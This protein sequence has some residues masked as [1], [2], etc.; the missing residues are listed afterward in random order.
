MEGTKRHCLLGG[1][2]AERWINCPP[3]ARL[4]EDMDD[5]TSEYAIEGTKAHALC[6]YKL[7]RALGNKAEKPDPSEFDRQMDESS[8]GYVSFVLEQAESA[9]EETGDEPVTMVEHEVAYDSWVKGG[10]GTCDALIA[11]SGRL[12]VID[13]KYG[14][15]VKVDATDNSQLKIYALGAIQELDCLYDFD[16]VL[17]TIYQPRIGNVSTWE[18]TKAELLKWAEEVLKPAAE[19][20]DRGEGIYRSGPW[21]RFCK[22]RA[23]CRE[24]S[25]VARD[26]LN[27]EFRNPD[28]LSDTEIEEI[29]MKADEVASYLSDLKDY[30]LA[31]A[32][33]GKKWV[34]FKLV[35]GRSVRKFT[36][37]GK[38]I[39]VL[40]EN[41]VNPFDAKLRSITDIEKE[42]GKARFKALLDGYVAK[43]KGKPTLAPR[44]DRREEIS[45]AKADFGEFET[46]E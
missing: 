42:L 41:H 43:P 6:E 31:K 26:I 16:K 22:A 18:T 3:S 21:C 19:L 33:E 38:V 10:F 8:D 2:S 11:C 27:E 24:R 34:N 40:K 1:S 15:G 12:H 45:P 5:Q 13:F 4:T 9:K 36:D 17:L 39:A 32:L 23:V 46:E 25:R 29:L 7:N 44:S 20:A 30:A 28:L 35:E 37:E 14:L